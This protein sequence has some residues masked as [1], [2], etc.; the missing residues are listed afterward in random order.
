[1][2]C[3]SRGAVDDDTALMRRIRDDDAVFDELLTERL[4]Q[5]LDVAEGLRPVAFNRLARRRSP[6]AAGQPWGTATANFVRDLRAD[7]VQLA[8]IVLRSSSEVD[9]AGRG[10]SVASGRSRAVSTMSSRPGA[11]SVLSSGSVGASSAI[12]SAVNSR[13]SSRRRL[14]APSTLASIPDLLDADSTVS[15]PGYTI[16]SDLSFVTT[17][18]GSDTRLSCVC[19]LLFQTSLDVVVVSI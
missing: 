1:M 6:S 17:S 5:F 3:Q 4:G 7:A 2:S 15:S 11:E 13:R 16:R 9:R 18:R 12:T 14:T 8:R 10:R 19:S